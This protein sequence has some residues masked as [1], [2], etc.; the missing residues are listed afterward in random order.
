MTYFTRVQKY[1]KNH[2]PK[3]GRFSSGKGGGS[4]GTGSTGSL[5][6]ESGRSKAIREQEEIDSI[7]EQLHSSGKYKEVMEKALEHVNSNASVRPRGWRNSK[8]RTLEMFRKARK[9]LDQAS[10]KGKD[11]NVF[12]A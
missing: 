11:P 3:D 9:L 10:Q 4:S 8:E 6:P 12:D 1:N 5:K 7:L 2:D